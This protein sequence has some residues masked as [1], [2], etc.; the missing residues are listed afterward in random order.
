M[1]DLKSARNLLIAVVLT[2]L[3]LGTIALAGVPGDSDADGLSDDE[4]IKHLFHGP[5]QPG[6]RFRGRWFA[7]CS[8]FRQGG[9]QCDLAVANLAQ[10]PRSLLRHTDRLTALPGQARIVKNQSS[11]AKNPRR[12]GN[13][14]YS[15]SVSSRAW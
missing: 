6:H 10:R 3:A 12:R 15:E 13:R 5:Q 1:R 14:C 11:P 2:F 8:S 4:E 7:A 9:R